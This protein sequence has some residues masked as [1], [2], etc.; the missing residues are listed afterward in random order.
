MP[1]DEAARRPRV[2]LAED[3]KELRY[4]VV[5]ALRAAGL[6]VDEVDTGV[7]LLGRVEHALSRG[8]AV[9]DVIVSDHRM[10]GLSGLDVLRIL[11]RRGS[12]IPFVLMTGFGASELHAEVEGHPNAASLDK[13]LD[14]DDLIDLI[15]RLAP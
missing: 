1:L 6:E 2:L 13:P 3:E 4:L 7:A 15:R 12:G 5:S 14:V 9:P 8:A 10:P 11:R